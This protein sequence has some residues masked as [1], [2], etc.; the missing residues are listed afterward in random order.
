LQQYFPNHQTNNQMSQQWNGR[1]KCG[2]GHGASS[3]AF[4]DH[5]RTG[6]ESWHSQ[7]V[8]EFQGKLRRDRDSFEVAL[9]CLHCHRNIIFNDHV[10]K[11][12]TTSHDVD[13]GFFYP[14]TEQAFEQ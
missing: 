9:E 14:K 12:D 6:D 2:D 1:I 13:K 5:K 11:N 3:G 4:S 8:D 7:S 10:V